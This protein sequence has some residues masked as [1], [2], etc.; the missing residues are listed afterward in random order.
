MHSPSGRVS[1]ASAV[2]AGVSQR[3][4]AKGAYYFSAGAVTSL[5]PGDDSVEAVVIGSLPY[6][7][8]ITREG[9]GFTATCECPYFVDRVE[10]CKH[11]WAVILAADSYRN[12]PLPGCL[13]ATTWSTST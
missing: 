12:G 2:Q 4:R 11:I 1:L 6:A 3:T 10:I 9:D 5:A 8:G 7:V 13:P